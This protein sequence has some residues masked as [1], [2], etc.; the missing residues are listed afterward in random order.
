MDSDRGHTITAQTPHFC[1]FYKNIE[2]YAHIVKV[3]PRILERG[4]ESEGTEVEA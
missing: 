1:K 4:L 3:S 2:P